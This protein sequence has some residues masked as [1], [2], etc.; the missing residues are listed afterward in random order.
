MEREE[1]CNISSPSWWVYL[2]YDEKDRSISRD[3]EYFKESCQLEIVRLQHPSFGIPLGES[4]LKMT[5]NHVPVE[6]IDWRQSPELRVYS[7]RRF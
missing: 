2:P 6:L 7:R 4:S 1:E 5:P 3:E